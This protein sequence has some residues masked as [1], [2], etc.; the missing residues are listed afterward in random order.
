MPVPYHLFI[1]RM[2]SDMS[3]LASL[4]ACERLLL[5]TGLSCFLTGALQRDD[6]VFDGELD[7]LGVG[8]A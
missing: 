3:T 8:L 7:Q 2:Q 1:F 5:F 4:D 6:V